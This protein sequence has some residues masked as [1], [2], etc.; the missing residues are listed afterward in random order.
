MAKNTA[1]IPQTAD[2]LTPAWF[3]STVGAK[4]NAVVTDVPNIT[5]I[6]EGIGFLGALYRCELSWNRDDE[7]LPRS[8]IVKVPALPGTNRSS[9]ETIQAYE[10]EIVAYRDLGHDMGLPMPRFFH[11]EMDP[12]PASW[13][14][15]IFN[16]LFEKLPMAAVNWL[17]LRLIGLSGKVQRRYV[18]VMEDIHDARPPTQTE[19]GSLEDTE[20]A[21]GVLATFHSHH[22]MRQDTVDEHDI[23]WPIDQTPKVWQCSFR[24]NRDEFAETFSHIVSDEQ[25][26]RLDEI[27]QRADKIT[28]QLAAAP[29]TLSHGDYRL[30]NILFRPDG[31]MVVLDYQGILK[32]RPG[33]DVAYFI[34]TAL[35]AE[36]RHEEERLLRIYHDAL[37]AAGVSD[38][39]FE[40]LVA[41]ATA[42]KEMIAHRMVVTIDTLETEVD[43]RDESFVE[44]LVGRVLAWL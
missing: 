20:A 35:T 24:R 11:A 44:T 43:G 40:H 13:L 34:T 14:I 16:F 30:D 1:H 18:L 38:Y 10:R 39:S 25:M 23:I 6:G 8:V 41:D 5:T 32:A 7:E 29:W 2:E 27:D 19:G 26:A 22:W 42:T 28:S 9:G 33:F 12:N 36:H 3:T 15:P 21:L 17:L 37:V 31:S 4:L